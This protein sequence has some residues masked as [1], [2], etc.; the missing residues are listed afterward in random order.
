MALPANPPH[1]EAITISG[2]KLNVPLKPIIPLITPRAAVLKLLH[3]D[4]LKEQEKSV[5]DL[6][7]KSS[8]E[9]EK[10]VELGREFENLLMRRSETS[11]DTWL[12]KART[13]SIAEIKFGKNA[14]LF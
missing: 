11:L 14:G 6:I 10:A 2:G 13:S 8:P 5:V 3:S 1:G 12:L 4:K 9:I 7:L